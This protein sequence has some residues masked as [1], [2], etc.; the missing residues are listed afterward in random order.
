MVKP[1][2]T[3]ERTFIAVKPDGVQRGLV[4]EIISRFE[5]RGLKLVACKMIT[6][7]KEFAGKHYA[8]LSKKPFFDGLCDFISSGP[9]FAM[10]WEGLNAAKTG[11]ALLGATNP[12]DSLPGTIRGDLCVD[13]GRNV[14]HG[15]D[16]PDSAKAE[17]ALWFKPEEICT[18]DVC[19]K[20]WVYEL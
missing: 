19:E 14:C 5:K 1:E 20:N 11:R 3:Q 4:G 13:I 8:D 9:V 2:Q 17:I 12:A 15:S 10:V 16:S 18:W 6:I 7:S